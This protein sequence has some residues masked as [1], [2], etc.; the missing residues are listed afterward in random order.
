MIFSKQS[1]VVGLSMFVSLGAC[2]SQSETEGGAD[3]A[4]PADSHGKRDPDYDVVFPQQRVQTLRLVIAGSDYAAMQSDLATL[5]GDAGLPGGGGFPGGGFPGGG[6]PEGG[7][8][9]FDG[10]IRPPAG[11]GGFPPG[12][13]GGGA[14]DIIGGDPIYVPV[15]VHF[16]GKAWLHAGIRYKGNSSLAASF[17]Q[18]IRKLPFRID[19]DQFEARWSETKDQRFYGFKKLTFAS[20][21]G[22]DSQVREALVAE[23]L[24]EAGVPSARWAFYRVVIDVG[25]GDEYLGL[26]TAIEDPADGAMLKRLFGSKSGNLYKPD[27]RGADWTA[28]DASGF[29]KKTNED[30][31]DFGDVQRAIAALHADRSDRT[32]WRCTLEMTFD[33]G[34]FIRWLAA[35]TTVQN[36]D[37]Y[38]AMAHNYYLYGVPS[39]HGRLVWIPWDHNLSLGASFGF[40]GMGAGGR[41]G[42]TGAQT[43]TQEFLHTNVDGSRWPLIRHVLDD[44]SYA[45][46]YRQELRSFLADHFVQEKVVARAAELHALVAPHVV[47]SRGEVDG[48]RTATPGA[49]EAAIDGPN[50]LASVIA[51]RYARGEEA[52]NA[53]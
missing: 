12:P 8:P 20:N 2:S 46:R 48:S 13:G 6:F 40:G 31:G 36:W 32:A 15:D 17:G 10:G 42:G 30:E 24:A 39:D 37:T 44:P 7:F 52:L 11:D 25:H 14:I 19:F 47:G 5:I 49:F 26:Y 38:G 23:L 1:F 33:V 21:F 53:R 34:G 28:F 29:E 45:E 50:G 51:T 3:A 16:D 22:D 9:G 35:N 41:P 18:G 4:A 43:A 27:G